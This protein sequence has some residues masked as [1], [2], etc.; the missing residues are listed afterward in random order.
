MITG[1]SIRTRAIAL[2]ATASML[3]GVAHAAQQASAPAEQSGTPSEEGEEIVVRGQRF[4]YE[5]A[6]SA[7]KV[8]LSI[9]DTPQTVV[10]ITKDML[11]FASVNALQDIYKL[12]ASAS[13]T[14]A[15]PDTTVN[16]Y[17]GFRQQS[18]NGVRIDGFRLNIDTPLDFA[19]FARIELVKGATSTLYGQNSIA[20]TM[21]IIS[22]APRSEFGGEI[23][24]EGGSFDQYRGEV[25]LYGPLTSDRRL[26]FRLVAAYSDRGSH[27]RFVNDRVAVI[28]PMLRYEFSPDT[29]ITTRINY[30]DYDTVPFFGP[31]LVYD[32]DVA[33]ALANGF[34]PAKLSRPDLPRNFFNGTAADRSRMK[35]L[36]W[37]TSFEH[38]FGNDW[39]LRANAQYVWGSAAWESI[40]SGYAGAD[41]VPTFNRQSK[42]RTSNTLYGGEI[43]LFGDVHALGGKHT[44]FFG[45]DY[46]RISF[47]ILSAQAMIGRLSMRDPDYV[48]AVPRRADFKDFDSF[49][50]RRLFQEDFGLTAQAMLRPVK[51]LTLIL[52][53]RYSRD[54]ISDQ[55]RTGPIELLDDQTAAPFNR[56]ELSTSKVTFQGG[57]TYA[58][59]AQTNLY[60]SYGQTYEPKTERQSVDTYIDPEEG[61]A[62]EIGLKGNLSRKLSYA[63]ALYYMTRS[64]I[65]QSRLG[66]DFYDPIGT[67]RSKGAE[68][69]LQGTV[70][71]GWE[72]YLSVSA[73]DAAFIDGDYKGLRPESAPKFGLSA[74]TSY[75]VQHGA[76]KGLGAGAGVVHKSSYRTFF[77][78]TDTRGRPLPYDMPAS[79]EVDLRA[80]Y[81]T[82][83]WNL[84]ASVT[85]LFNSRY[86]ALSHNGFAFGFNV[87]PGRAVMGRISRSF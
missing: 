60:A 30:Q 8:P 86:Q 1:K 53:T 23:M 57:A 13:A 26:T 4:Y 50:Q 10:A 2:F 5:E 56:S 33:E 76:L 84:S 58:L 34:D 21:N 73:L 80:F 27:L 87:N 35:N 67:Q 75:T 29:S 15:T 45:A 36:T 38:R 71:P 6:G 42:N 65:A 32:G 83:G 16:Y 77:A 52:G 22:K 25:D 41:Y 24:F 9:K 68:V 61:R 19:P 81:A 18:S 69:S 31:G 63:F 11:D 70:L 20:G 3:P 79:T 59:N 46:S 47:P 49:F 51:G 37:Q 48:K 66:S 12:D 72:A 40:F 55:I 78:E 54:R 39:R 14:H 64:N 62:Y 82:G 43:N 85:N 17:R 7:L 74:F 44:L 28:A